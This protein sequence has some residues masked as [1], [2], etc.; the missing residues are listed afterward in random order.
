MVP[1]GR[2]ADGLVVGRPVADG[3]EHD[4][5]AVPA[6]QLTDPL[7]ALVATFGDDVGGAELPA[8]VGPVGVAA[9]QHDLFGAEHLGGQHREQSHRAVTDHGDRGLAR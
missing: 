6:G 3:L 5:G 4:V 7:D 2:H 8:Q 1:P 9:H